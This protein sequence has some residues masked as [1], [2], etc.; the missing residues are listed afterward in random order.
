MA[1]Q[2]QTRHTESAARWQKALAR[3]IANGLEVFVVND[4]GERMVTSSSALDTLYRSDGRHCTCAAGLAGDPICQHR[5]VVRYVMGWLP[6][7]A[8][9]APALLPVATRRCLSCTNGKVEEIGVSGPIGWAPC[10]VCQGSGTLPAPQPVVLPV[11]NT[12]RIAA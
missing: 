2:V 11:G 7:P 3:A 10:S 12:K 4:T 1:V 6:A 5:A 8:S 9:G